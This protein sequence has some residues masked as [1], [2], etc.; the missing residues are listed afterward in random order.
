MTGTSSTE[1]A[2][3]RRSLTSLLPLLLP[4]PVL[5]ALFLFF[6]YVSAQAFYEYFG[7][8]ISALDQSSTTFTLRAANSLPRYARGL[9]VLPVVLVVVLVGHHLVARALGG[10]S[11]ERAKRSALA[12]VVAGVAAL[13]V[14]LA[15]LPLASVRDLV[16]PVV[17]ALG[18]LAVEYGLWMGMTSG[19]L[20]SRTAELVGSTALLRHGLVAAFV[21]L[22][23][24]W[25]VT[26]QAY[27]SGTAQAR[28]V[29]QTL[30]AQPTVVV[31]SEGDLRLAGPGVTVSD[32]GEVPGS[33]RY[34]YDGLRPLVHA[35][36]AWFLLPAGWTRS[37]DA[38]VLVL[39]DDAGVR[40]ELAPFRIPPEG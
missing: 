38:R 40:V 17:L 35:N 18:A 28:R 2:R 30:A 5:A 37:G 25:V 12:T 16:V 20:P 26:V 23:L 27:A 31:Y 24:L 4:T 13:L 33:Y 9:I 11:T 34:A 7:V 21:T 32:L 3:T 36:G 39:P 19:T 8:A 15:M 6:G 10:A 29:E 22:A 1:P 14:G